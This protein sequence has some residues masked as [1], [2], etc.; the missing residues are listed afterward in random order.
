[1]AIVTNSRVWT[2][3]DIVNHILNSTDSELVGS[4]TDTVESEQVVEI[5][6]GTFFNIVSNK[7]WEAHRTAFKLDSFGDDTKPTHMTL[8]TSIREV[9]AINYNKRT[10]TA[11]SDQYSECRYVTPE[12]FLRLTNAKAGSSTSEQVIDP[13]GVVLYVTNNAAPKFYT[14]FN[15]SYVVFDSY[16]SEVDTTL[17]SA[18]TQCIGFTHPQ[19]SVADD[20]V[21]DLPEDA[22]MYL[23][24]DSKSTASI[25]LRQ[26]ADEKAEQRSNK[27]RRWLSR[28]SWRVAGGFQMPDYGRE[29]TGTMRSH[30]FPPKR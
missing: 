17:Q 8:P 30:H 3:L 24:E 23:I 22:M 6:K 27:Q 7:N 13:S 2:L 1:M 25:T 28:N 11:T 20:Y 18:K 19:F 14:S 29:P 5:V 21:P 4:I 15:D 9:L 10:L 12:E 26:M 16:D